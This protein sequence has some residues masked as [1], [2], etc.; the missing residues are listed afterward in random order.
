MEVDGR[1]CFLFM[2]DGCRFKMLIFQGVAKKNLTRY[3]HPQKTFIIRK[4]IVADVGI[5]MY[6]R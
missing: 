6:C 4:A 5:V 2:G 3:S 1:F